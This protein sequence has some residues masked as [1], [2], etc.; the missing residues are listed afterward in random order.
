[1]E[2]KGKAKGPAACNSQAVS[3]F[4]RL[5]NFCLPFRGDFKKCLAVV[6]EGM[7]SIWSYFSNLE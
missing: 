6:F 5:N 7:K 1:M 2:S 3:P 4:G